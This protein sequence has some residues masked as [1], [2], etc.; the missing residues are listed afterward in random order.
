MR[1]TE[2]GGGWAGISPFHEA[3]EP[4]RGWPWTSSWEETG[5]SEAYTDSGS[6]TDSAPLQAGDLAEAFQ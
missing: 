1:K 5:S 3:I 2:D 4:G 6:S